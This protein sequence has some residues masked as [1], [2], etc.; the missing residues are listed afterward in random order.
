MEGSAG[1]G[2]G[3]CCEAARERARTVAVA[4]VVLEALLAQ[5]QG[6][7]GDVRRVHGLHGEAR[8]GAVEVGVRHQ[9]LH[10]LQQLLEQ[11]APR[12]AGLKHGW[13]ESF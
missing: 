7:E 11:D 9:V 4:A 1:Q 8:G 5:V 2:K 3:L 12:Q 10:R 6:H 13:Q